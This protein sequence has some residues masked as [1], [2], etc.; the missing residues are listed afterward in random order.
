MEKEKCS[1]LSPLW[2]KR[3]VS[4][5]MGGYKAFTLIELLVVVL[6]IGILA[7]V[8]VP[9]YTK[10][11]EK[12]HVAQAVT[13]LNAIY[14]GHQLCMLQKGLGSCNVT[15]DLLETMD[16][17]LPGEIQ[18][19]EENC[20]DGTVCIKN[21]NW[22]FVTDNSAEFYA[23]RLKNEEIAYTLAL[24]LEEGSEIGKITCWDG[25]LSFCSSLC[26]SNGCFLN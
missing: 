20:I 11:V 6:I 23:N 5:K 22:N 7:A 12:A 26:G 24:R 14:K 9:Q 4:D 3:R 13:F 10:A 18:K 1:F 17:E 16:I 25:N 21:K 2:G 8:A 19:E 15:E